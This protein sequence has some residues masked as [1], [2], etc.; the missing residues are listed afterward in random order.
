MIILERDGKYYRKRPIISPV[1]S[2][3][4]MDFHENGEIV[5]KYDYVRKEI[6]FSLEE[7]TKEE[8]YNILNENSNGED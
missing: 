8:Y 2:P 6:G 1:G 7:I 4:K 5:S 3:V